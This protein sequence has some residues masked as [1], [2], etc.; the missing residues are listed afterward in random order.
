MILANAAAENKEAESEVQRASLVLRIRESGGSLSR[1]LKTVEV[2]APQ[3]PVQPG[4][5]EPG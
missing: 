3:W 1:I 5:A 4:P 2:S